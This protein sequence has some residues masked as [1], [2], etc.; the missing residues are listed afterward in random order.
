MKTTLTPLSIPCRVVQNG[1]KLVVEE[2]PQW[3]GRKSP[4]QSQVWPNGTWHGPF[5][6]LKGAD[7]VAT[8]VNC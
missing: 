6:S 3:L 5:T 2:K 1:T 7:K 4:T 8:K